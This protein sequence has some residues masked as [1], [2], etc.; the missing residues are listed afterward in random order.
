M[1]KRLIQQ[2]RGKGSIFRALSH[3][4]LAKPQMI[5][6]R[7]EIIDIVDD[8]V[9]NT[10]LLKLLQDDQKVAYMLASEGSKVGDIVEINKTTKGSICELRNI[11]A[12]AQFF[13]IEVT[14]TS[15]ATIVRTPGSFATILN[16][17]ANKVLV[18]LPSKKTK[19]FASNCRAIIGIAAGSGQNE[20]PFLKAGNKH[21]A[22][23]A[24]R[25]LYPVV[26]GTAMNACSH[27]HGG[28]NLG[29]STT[30]SRRKSSP[31]AK[32][33]SISSKRTGRG[34]KK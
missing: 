15:D 8:P 16:K 29:R 17:E 23:A 34:R 12:G 13:N 11:P 32:V 28:K 18:Q 26:R 24:K 7:A 20:K 10:P 19:Y 22:K 4:A 33:G 31:G 27:P 5:S 30:I 21:F 2:R 25:K 3:H 14:P 6:Q 1:G 9:R